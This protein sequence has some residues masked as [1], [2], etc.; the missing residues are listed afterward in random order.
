MLCGPTLK[1]IHFDNVASEL[2]AQSRWAE[3]TENLVEV[4]EKTR[5]LEDL[6]LYMGPEVEIHKTG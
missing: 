1:E 5:S 4:V 3:F 6:S 2:S